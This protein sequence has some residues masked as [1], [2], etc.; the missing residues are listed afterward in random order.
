[1][2]S[3]LSAPSSRI[4]LVQVLHI[5]IN[6]FFFFVTALAQEVNEALSGPL[7]LLTPY[8]LIISV[9]SLT[10]LEFHPGSKAQVLLIAHP[11]SFSEACL[12]S[13]ST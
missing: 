1:M 2:M 7:H 3:Q 5:S 9:I 10:L 11:T 12:S 8:C 13:L 6:A 4:P